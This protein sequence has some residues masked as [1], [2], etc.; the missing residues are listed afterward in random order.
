[1]KAVILLIARSP[2]A[3]SEPKKHFFLPLER[4]P[5]TSTHWLSAENQQ[6][7]LHAPFQPTQNDIDLVS[8][9][10]CKLPQEWITRQTQ[11]LGIDPSSARTNEEWYALH[12][13]RGCTYFN[14]GYVFYNYHPSINNPVEYALV[15]RW[16]KNMFVD[17]MNVKDASI[18]QFECWNHHIRSYC[19]CESYFRKQR[20]HPHLEDR[21]EFLRLPCRN[22]TQKILIALTKAPK[23]LEIYWS[24]PRRSQQKLVFHYQSPL[25]FR[26]QWS[27]NS[28]SPHRSMPSRN[29]TTYQR[30]RSCFHS[31]S[32]RISP[33]SPSSSVAILNQMLNRLPIY[34]RFS[35]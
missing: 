23:C 25:C 33:N 12:C 29:S 32:Q 10:A 28:W 4:R 6:V 21:L 11:L 22:E 1:M 13:I 15:T 5:I 3:L 30:Q 9:H 27:S 18:P 19:R 34:L 20:S 2:R 24:Q 17:V 31:F 16:D 35:E 8:H 7:P 26:L 14:C